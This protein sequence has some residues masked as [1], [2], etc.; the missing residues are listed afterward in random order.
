M[1]IPEKLTITADGGSRGNPG[2]AACAFAV[3]DSASFGTPTAQP[4]HQQ[5]FYLGKTTNNQAEYKGFLASLRWLEK[6]P[7]PPTHVHWQMDSMLVVEQMNGRWKIKNLHLQIIYDQCQQLLSQLF[8]DG[9]YSISH[10]PRSQNS[11]ADTL[12]NLTLDQHIR[13]HR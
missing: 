8:P 7:H 9:N 1:T 4:L 11:V 3:W 12:V 5:G 13:H 10:A 6:L 2:P